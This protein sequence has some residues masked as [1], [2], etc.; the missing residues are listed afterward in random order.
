MWKGCGGFGVVRA[1]DADA[2]LDVPVKR[3]LLRWAAED[4]GLAAPVGVQGSH[5]G[6]GI[7]IQGTI[8]P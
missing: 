5:S 1:R 6:V 3:R 2:G 4:V 7:Q 8:W